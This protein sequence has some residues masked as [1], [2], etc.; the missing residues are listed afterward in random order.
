MKV[1]TAF[2]IKDERLLTP[3]QMRFVEEYVSDSTSITKAAIRAGY[4]IKTAYASGSNLMGDPRIQKYL[5]DAQDRAADKL[6]ITAEKVMQ[7]LWKVAGANPGDI[8]TVNDLGET[9]ID[10][11]KIVGEVS[12][13]TVTG[14]NRPKIRSVTSKTVKPADKIAALSQLAKLLNMFPKQEIE[15]KTQFSFAEAVLSAYPVDALPE[16]LPILES[17]ATEVLEVE[18]TA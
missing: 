6:G 7:E 3:M 1:D 8:V 13:T 2:A 12:V 11:T 5:Q 17:T 10:S 9:D 4:S 14:G 18:D 15:V 16:P